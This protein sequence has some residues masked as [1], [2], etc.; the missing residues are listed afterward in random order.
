MYESTEVLYHFIYLFIYLILIF[1]NFYLFL[2]ERHNASGGRGGA[3]REGE[4]E[5]EAGSSLWAISTEPDGELEPM[6]SEITTQAEVSCLTDWATHVLQVLCHF[7]AKM[8]LSLF[9][10]LFWLCNLSPKDVTLLNEV[11]V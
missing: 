8:V 6:D 7:I 3:E 2:R 1:K 9:L 5:S 10:A 4:T 11:K